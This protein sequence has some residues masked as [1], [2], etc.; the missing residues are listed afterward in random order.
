MDKAVRNDSAETSA[1]CKIK[2]RTL[3]ALCI[4]FTRPWKRWPNI[5]LLIIINAYTGFLIFELF[6]RRSALEAV[7]AAMLFTL[8]TWAV[9]STIVSLLVNEPR[10]YIP[11]G[12]SA[13]QTLKEPFRRCP[14]A[15]MMTLMG[16]WM[17]CVG[18][19]CVLRDYK[20]IGPA[21]DTPFWWIAACWP[22]IILFGYSAFAL[23]IKPV[24]EDKK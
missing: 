9:Y 24:K 22:L 8:A 6:I 5:S 18:F 17:V 4:G 7:P 23:H 1:V 16:W 14:R 20:M 15:A 3:R 19:S 21:T 13:W 2:D 10:P 12:P 11:T